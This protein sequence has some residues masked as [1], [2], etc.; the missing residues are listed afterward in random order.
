MKKR[1]ITLVAILMCVA[2]LTGCGK[3]NET[4][5][6]NENQENTEQTNE[7]QDAGNDVI[8]DRA[9]NEITLPKEVN[10]IISMAPSTS[11]IIDELGMSD[12]F[13]AVDTQT[14][15]YVEG[16]DELPQ[17]D[18]MTPDCE[19]LLELEPDIVFVTGMSYVGAENPYEELI[20]AGVCVAQIPSSESIEAIK[21]DI[22]FVGNCLGKIEES[23]EI[24]EEMQA[25]IDAVAAIGETITDK[26]TVLFEIAALPDIYS[27]GNGVFLQEML[28]LIGAENVFA[29]QQSWIAVT[30]E[31]AVTANP[32]VILTSVNYIENPVG[33]ILSRSGWENVEAIKN[34]QVYSIDN[35]SSSLPNHNIVI[36]L[37]QMAKAIYPDEYAGL[38]E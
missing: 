34:Q 12:C 11:Q 35:G 17:F 4:P 22:L 19:A 25:E 38:E 7:V 9:G 23:K 13:I 27:F 32:D 15:M 16:L 30:E 36:A 8:T 2:M 33:E 3:S 1:K 37:K 6:G 31:S 20:T 29:D 5:Q 24:V 10:K 14:P 28:E 21:E 18:M 26:K